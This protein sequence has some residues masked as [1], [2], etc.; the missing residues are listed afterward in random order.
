MKGIIGRKIGMTRIFNEEGKVIPVT[1]IEAGP[2]PVVQVRTKDRDGYDAIQIG[3]GSRKERRTSMPLMGQFRKAGIEP[4]RVL[5]E[6]RT[7]DISGA[8]VG[9]QV[10]ADIFQV[11]ERVKVTGFS[12]GKGFQGVVKRWGFSGGG[13]AHGS[14]SHRKPGSIGQCAT[15]AKVW[16]NRKMPGRAGHRRTTIENLEVVQ[17]DP[18]RNMIAIKGAVPGHVKGYVLITG[19]A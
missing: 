18:E 17:V 7:E 15:P 13:D 14:K 3:F 1:V 11:G 5:R 6:I 19:K 8:E 2:C 16:K 9:S 10:K 4:T 12:K